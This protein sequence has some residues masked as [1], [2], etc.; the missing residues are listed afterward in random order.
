MKCG[1]VWFHARH[2]SQIPENE[3]QDFF[4]TEMEALVRFLDKLYIEETE[5]WADYN[6]T[7]ARINRD[8]EEVYK[9]MTKVME[10]LKSKNKV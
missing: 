9:A 4:Q 1:E 6:L 7:L 3:K 2:E 5:T 8:K 10:R